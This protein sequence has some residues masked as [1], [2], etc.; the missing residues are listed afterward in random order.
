MRHAQG[1]ALGMIAVVQGW[2][3]AAGT[4]V[5]EAQ[6]GPPQLAASSLMAALDADWD[7]PAARDQ[8]LAQVPGFD[9][10]EAFIADPA[11]EQAAATAV[12]AARQIRD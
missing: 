8:A 6:A 9:L 7:D 3:Q 5:V 12:A 10:V 4:A 1:K 11:G 2:G